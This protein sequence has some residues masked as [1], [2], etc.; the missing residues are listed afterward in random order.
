MI[1]RGN[2]PIEHI[3]FFLDQYRE[4]CRMIPGL[5]DRYSTLVTPLEQG[6]IEDERCLQPSEWSVNEGFVALKSVRSFI[7]CHRRWK[8]SVR[9]PPLG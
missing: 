9:L 6:M 2:G 5:G 7:Q 1:A 8:T 4:F 3:D